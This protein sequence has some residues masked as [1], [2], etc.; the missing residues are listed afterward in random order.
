MTRSHMMSENMERFLRPGETIEQLYA[1]SVREVQ[2]WRKR[3]RWTLGLSWGAFIL[4]QLST[5]APASWAQRGPAI[6]VMSFLLVIG[7][8][9]G[10]LMGM[11][12]RPSQ[13]NALNSLLQTDDVRAVGP[14]LEA[15]QMMIPAITGKA[16]DALIR[17]LPSLRE[18]HATLLTPLQK[19]Y[20]RSLIVADA[21]R[22]PANPALSTVVQLSSTLNLLPIDA[23]NASVSPFTA[24]KFMGY[25]SEPLSV[26]VVQALAY[27]GDNNDLELIQRIAANPV[28]Q[29]ALRAQSLLESRIKSLNERETHLRVASVP[30]ASP[31]ELRRA[32][33]PSSTP[34][35]PATLVRPTQEELQAH[36]VST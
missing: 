4:G 13:R 34:S 36:S 18:E 35:D 30:S 29:A 31:D 5:A 19:R 17:L 28:Q 8:L 3:R 32:A 22:R 20:L 26:A 15:M 10:L 11:L 33:Q 12:M 2:K 7:S 1:R 16:A 27:I 21:P 9:L 25:H 24:N 14:L 6:P 23:V